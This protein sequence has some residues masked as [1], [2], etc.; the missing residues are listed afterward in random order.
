MQQRL[1]RVV[2]LHAPAQT[3]AEALGTERHRHELLNVDAGVSVRATVDDV[4]E[5]HGQRAR[6]RTAEVAE[7]WQAGR[8]GRGVRDCEAHAENG[9]RAEA[10]LVLGAVNRDERAV[11]EALVGRVDQFVGDSRAE[12]IEDRVDGL[13]DAL[14][15]VAALVAVAQL[16]CFEG[17]G[18]RT[19]RHGR[20]AYRAVCQ[21][22]LD[23]DRRV[24]ARV[25]NLACDHR[26][27]KCHRVLLGFVCGNFVKFTGGVTRHAA[28][29]GIAA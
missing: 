13:R 10:L 5:R 22:D 19:A 26:V 21:A 17:T 14:A 4:H 12:L 20:T 1:E 24:A 18:R 15:E 28:G 29:T 16:V 2:D 9:V 27:Y 3:L 8:L 23:L 11:D 7:E 25:K 6:G